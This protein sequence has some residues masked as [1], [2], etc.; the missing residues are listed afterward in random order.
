MTLKERIQELGKIEKISMN[1]LEMELGFGSGYISKLNASKPNTDKIEKIANK[2]NVT[3]DFL[4]G[5][6]DM[7]V[8]PVCG[9]GNN[10]LSDMSREEHEKFHDRFLKIREIYLPYLPKHLAD[11]LSDESIMRFWNKDLSIKERLDAFDEYLVAQYSNE[12]RLASDNDLKHMNFD[13]FCGHQVGLIVAWDNVD[14]EIKD[15]LTIKY[16]ADFDYVYNDNILIER[17]RN[18]SQLIRILKYAEMLNPEML[19]S[20][21]VQIK[22]LAEQKEKE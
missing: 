17:V 21:E 19:N 5:R 1:Q 18:N 6:T 3:V 20:I 4:L 8:C 7:V 10:P 9:F 2:L 16:S 11:R 15:A 22:A 13:K 12:L 14:D